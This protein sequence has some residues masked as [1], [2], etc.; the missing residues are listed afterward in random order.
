MDIKLV[1]VGDGA[2]G[3]TSLLSVFV[4]NKFPEDYTP[5]VF[6]NQVK[7]IIIDSKE[8][9][10]ALWDTAGQ[11]DYEQL[12]PLSYDNVDVFV[13]VFSLDDPGSLY[14]IRDLWIPELNQYCGKGNVPVIVVGNK[15]DLRKYND[16][17][18]NEIMELTTK[19]EAEGLAK[20]VGAESFIECSALTGEKVDDVFNE[21]VKVTRKFGGSRRN[22]N[23]NGKKW[24]CDG[25]GKCEIL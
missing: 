9:K 5:T 10:L 23:K 4:N 3:K 14:N 21:A 12:R 2:C 13:I 17:P 8:V 24:K 1:I 18:G 6:D 22:S 19:G 25:T 7:N 20:E 16:K 11:E 15:S